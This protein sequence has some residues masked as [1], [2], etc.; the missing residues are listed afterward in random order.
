MRAVTSSPLSPTAPRRASAAAQRND[1]CLVAAPNLKVAAA[2][3][4]AGKLI[5]AGLITEIRAKAGAP[6]WRRDDEAGLSY[7]L[8]L[9]AA[10]AEAIVIDKSAEPGHVD[11]DGDLREDVAPA[12]SSSQ[13]HSAPDPSSVGENGPPRGG[14][15]RGDRL[16]APFR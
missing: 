14:G 3:K 6:V 16:H 8:K 4:I 7:A 10:G 15:R 1:C 11:D 13:E 2:R 5:S 9:T 12:R